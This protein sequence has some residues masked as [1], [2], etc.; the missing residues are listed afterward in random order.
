M[1][2]EAGWRR[3]SYGTVEDIAQG[4]RLLTA[5]EAG[6]ERK[7]GG[8]GTAAIL[9]FE[10]DFLVQGLTRWSSGG[11][12]QEGSYGTV[13]TRFDGGFVCHGL[14]VPR[15]WHRSSSCILISSKSG[16]DLLLLIA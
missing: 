13:L 5:R 16:F 7:W 11:G 9:F 6:T 3:E 14:F 8:Y 4:D 15:L 2:A 12:A 10:H 1:E